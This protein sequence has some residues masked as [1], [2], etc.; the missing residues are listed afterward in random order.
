M[1][2]EPRWLFFSTPDKGTANPGNCSAT[3]C[4]RICPTMQRC[5]LRG[6]VQPECRRKN[7]YAG[8]ATSSMAPTTTQRRAVTP[9]TICPPRSA[10]G[11]GERN[12]GGGGNNQGAPAAVLAASSHEQAGGRAAQEAGG[13]GGA[14]RS[15]SRL[16]GEAWA[17]G[18][19]GAAGMI[20]SDGG[21]ALAGAGWQRLCGGGTAE[22]NHGSARSRPL[23]LRAS[24][25]AALR[26]PPA[27]QPVARPRLPRSPPPPHP[28]RHD[29]R[30]PRV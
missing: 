18:L 4:G 21:L 6:A 24:S 20:C 5:G 11:T 25:S 7:L 22:S 19:A 29:R 8:L 9:W 16:R 1:C 14:D 13:G 15:R 2:R 17:S 12:C 28:R 26:C 3:G 10:D 27:P 30:R 23:P